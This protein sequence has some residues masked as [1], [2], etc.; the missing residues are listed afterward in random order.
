LWTL[1]WPFSVKRPT[2]IAMRYHSGSLIFP[3]SVAMRR[4]C[5]ARRQDRHHRRLR[6]VVGHVHVR[7]EQ[8][9]GLLQ[10]RRVLRGDAGAD[11]R[12][13]KRLNKNAGGRRLAR[14]HDLDR[15][16][17]E[18]SFQLKVPTTRRTDALSVVREGSA[19]KP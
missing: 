14:R 4:I 6:P 13:V 17:V 12:F 11:D 7:A 9:L 16:R 2:P 1:R 19:F 8:A 5:G 3:L 18:A 15:A 10:L